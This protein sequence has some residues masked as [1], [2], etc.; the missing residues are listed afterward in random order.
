MKKFYYI[1]YILIIISVSLTMI[2]QEECKVLVPELVGTYAGKCKKGLANGHGR[3]EGKDI[4]EGQFLKGLPDG[5]GTYNWANGDVYVGEWLRGKRDGVGE[6]T[7]KFNEKDSIIQGVWMQDTYIGPVPA[8]PRVLYKTGVDRYTFVKM[9]TI[10]NRVLVNL[11]M[12]GAKNTGIEEFRLDAS[13]G[14]LTNLGTAVGYEFITFP[15]RM[16]VNY[17]TW[18]KLHTAR[19]YVVFEFEISEP[20]EWE[21]DIHN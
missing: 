18:N 8:P 5:K 16:K 6:F 10:Q 3:A 17:L 2:G 15:V 13:S 20:G 21:V 4:Y 12:N 7:F 19:Y 1:L 11:Y 9:G 14:A